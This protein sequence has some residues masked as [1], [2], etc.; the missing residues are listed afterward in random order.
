MERSEFTSEQAEHLVAINRGVAYVPPPIPENLTLTRSL[1]LIDGDARGAV[2]ELVGE[3]RRVQASLVVAP[4]RRREA[5][6]SNII[7]GPYTQVEDVLLGEAL[8]SEAPPVTAET[9]EVLRTLEAI[10]IGE[11][12]L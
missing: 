2:G 7:E 8:A 1:L 10:E 9:T 11:Q 12:W 3:A 5:V 4:L 6:L